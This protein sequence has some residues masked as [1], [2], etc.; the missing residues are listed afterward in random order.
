MPFAPLVKKQI[1]EAITL[2]IIP[3]LKSAVITQ[4]SA[5]PPFYFKG[6][7][8]W[9]IRQEP[10]PDQDRLPF[11]LLTHW[12]EDYV[13]AKRMPH[14]GFLY[15]GANDER[16][17][18][19]KRTALALEQ[20]NKP[21][22][23]GVTAIRLAA[24]CAFYI[25]AGV[26][27]TDGKLFERDAELDEYGSLSKLSID[28]TTE[29]LFV[30][31]FTEKT[32]STH[33][34]HFTNRQ[35]PQQLQEY[36]AFL[37]VDQLDKAQRLLLT[38]FTELIELLQNHPVEISNSSWP[39]V[40]ESSIILSSDISEANFRICCDAIQYI[41]LH[42]NTPLTRDKIAQEIG[43]SPVH[44]NR[45]FKKETK[46]TIMNFV[47]QYRLNAA[48]KML[49]NN[50]ERIGEIATLVGFASLYSMSVVFKRAY[51][52]SPSAYRAMEL[53]RQSVNK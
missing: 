50:V 33:H 39:S 41:Q 6:V 37:E 19:T 17:G 5:E 32:G 48:R 40:H 24:P 52:M 30:Y 38:I 49:E 18:I 43:V 51:G 11:D 9:S 42:L 8:H 26:P 44:L 12:K 29:E 1:G 15:S 3:L 22:P 27:R 46:L 10:L 20:T 35:L 23:S 21:V 25:P 4:V 45:V 7:R 31:L 13:L 14:L 34:L 16:W 47:T 53:N 2:H 36:A 28:F